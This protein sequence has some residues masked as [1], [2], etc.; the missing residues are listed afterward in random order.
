MASPTVFAIRRD[1]IRAPHGT[2]SL[3]TG[4]CQGIGLATAKFLLSLHQ[5]NRLVILDLKAPSDLVGSERVLFR[6]CDVTDWPSLRSGFEAGISKFG[7]IDN[8]FVNAGVNEYGNQLFLD[9]LDSDGKLKRPDSR[10][11]SI[12]LDAAVSTIKLA[13]HHMQHR[14]DG[15]RGGN[16]VMTASLA[17]YLGSA[18]APLY[19][20]A[21][22]GLVGLLRALKN[23][24]AKLG[25]AISLVAPGITLT[26]L[27]AGRGHNESLADWAVRMRQA[28]V[29]INDPGEVA[30]A[31]VWLMNLGLQANGKGLLIQAG[32]VADVEEGTAKTRNLWMSREMLDLFKGGRNAPLFP[33]KL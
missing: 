4:G 20:A 22:H 31:V 14:K 33:N 15:Q 18:G 5:D 25:I 12:D 17:G 13:I 19:S 3:I 6:R 7:H 10:V 9:E 8:V 23:D 29:P 26:D 1:E 21:K 27:V 16:I 30:T 24:T 28:G 2:V 11:L 32:R